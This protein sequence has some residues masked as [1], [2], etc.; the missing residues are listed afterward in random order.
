LPPDNGKPCFVA[1]TIAISNQSTDEIDHDD[2]T[3]R[4]LVEDGGDG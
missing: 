3:I 4:K 2:W 1:V